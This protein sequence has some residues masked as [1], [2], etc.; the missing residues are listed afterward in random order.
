VIAELRARRASSLYAIASA[1]NDRDL[2]TASGLWRPS[3]TC[4]PGSERHWDEMYLQLT[5]RKA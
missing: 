2:A 5:M 3:V 1:L 4:S